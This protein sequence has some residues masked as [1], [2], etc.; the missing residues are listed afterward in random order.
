MRL[1]KKSLE[2]E[3]DPGRRRVLRNLGLAGGAVAAGLAAP[4]GMMAHPAEPMS[5]AF[6][7][8]DSVLQVGEFKMIYDPSPGEKERWYINDHTFIRAVNSRWHLY[9]ITHREPANA[10]EEKFFAHATAPDLMGPW[11][12]QAS[13]LHVDEKHQETIVWA[14]YVLR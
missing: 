2:H 6:S 3:F 10:Q 4:W 13:V 8:P 7:A 1:S 11:T 9:G 5:A 12:K 14:P